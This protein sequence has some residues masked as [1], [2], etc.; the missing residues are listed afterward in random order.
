[1]PLFPKD[2]IE[3][4][5]KHLDFMTSTNF[6][7]QF[8]ERKEI[9]NNR[10]SFD[11][12]SKH[13]MRTAS[14][15]AN[16]N[17]EGGLIILGIDD[18]GNII[19]VKSI[20]E[21]GLNSI[22]Q[23]FRKLK[24][25]TFTN[26]NFNYTNIN[27]EEDFI[28]LVY[29]D[30]TTDAICETLEDFPR[31]WKRVGVQNM[32]L[33]FQELEALKRNKG[34][35]NFESQTCIEFQDND[36][37]SEIYKQFEK[38]FL[39]RRDS[40]FEYSKLE[41]LRNIG[42]ITSQNNIL[43]FTKSGYLY[44]SYNP[45]SIIAS[46]FVRLLKYDC[47][48]EDWR[49]NNNQPIFD[50]DFDGPIINIIRDV[51][52]FI[53][54]A[55]YFRTLYKR[56]ANGGFVNELEYPSVVVDEAI[57]NAIIHRDY[58]INVPIECIAFK[59]AFIVKS[60]GNIPQTAPKSFTL[61]E[62]SLESIPRNPKI[63]EWTRYMKDERGMT[64]IR[65][66]SEGTRT[67]R[68]KME[69]FDLPPPKYKNESFTKVILYNNFADREKRY[70]LKPE[71]EQNQ[72]ANL[73][74][75]SVPEDFKTD[76][77]HQTKRSLLL[78][79]RDV[80]EGNEWSIDGLYYSRLYAYRD[81]DNIGIESDFERVFKLY[82]IHEFQIKEYD[83]NY[84][85]S[86]DYRV[87]IKNQVDLQELIKYFEN[88]YFLGKNVKVRLGDS[89]EIAKLKTYN[90]GSSV[91]N[92][93]DV[94]D[95]DEISTTSIIPELNYRDINKVL[96]K[97]NI[98]VDLDKL[99]KSHSMLFHKNAA[100]IR[101]DKI[102]LTAKILQDRIFPIRIDKTEVRLNSNPKLF[103]KPS[104][105]SFSG[106]ITPLTVYHDLSE[107]YVVFHTGQIS[108]NILNGI[109]R[110]GS[111]E[112]DANDIEIIP[113]S[114][115]KYKLEMKELIVRL[116]VG[117]YKYRGSE[118]TF[119]TRFK[120]EKIFT[121]DD[122]KDMYNLVLDLIQKNPDWK[123]D[124]DISRIFL[125]YLPEEV[126]PKTDYQSP[127]YSIKKLLLGIGIPSQ[128][129]SRKTILS[130]DWK[131]LNLALNIVAKCKT[132]PWV[133]PDELPD[134]D[135]FIGL[136]YTSKKFETIKRYMGYANVFNQYGRWQLYQGN[137]ET[138]DYEDRHKFFGDLVRETLDKIQLSE[139]PSIVFHYSSKFSRKDIEIMWSAAKSIR[140][141]GKYTFI[142]INTTHNIRLFDTSAQTDGSLSRGSF[143]ITS[144]YQFYLSTTG[145]N[146][147]S[148]AMGTPLPLEV[149]VYSLT[150]DHPPNLK[151]I[152]KQI[153]YLT[154]LN[155]ASSKSLSRL[156][157]TIKY[158]KDIAKLSSIFIHKG[159]NL[160]IHKVL[161]E[162]PW[163]I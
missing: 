1:M 51:R 47:N 9:L 52:K 16:S 143:V 56:D 120:Y 30:H 36:L 161:Q 63:V 130:M 69:E 117:K 48:L 131:D 64:F 105:A 124:K 83:Q 140:P 78:A 147:Y 29:I 91:V 5:S 31:S 6:E 60:P 59:D 93:A 55:A 141:N 100:K 151:I 107:P 126:Y 150:L 87:R 138:F 25:L 119:G 49:A 4:P 34:I 71:L 26:Q 114:I 79:L 44:F 13:I 159:Q 115:T 7:G 113:L 28:I 17:R 84:Y 111:Y 77:R 61:D 152:A 2:L 82:N 73:F 54:D 106:K 102:L 97:K 53:L 92:F 110:F 62:I 19:G 90:Q 40:Q 163:F 157:V 14:G 112:K 67:M 23:I 12:V 33:S 101:A 137:P 15:F 57:V 94:N 144:P 27:E 109:T 86:F 116:I 66:L 118:R 38:D 135:F 153:L 85:L 24:N 43:Y 21:Q 42:A 76:D 8:F 18:E 46:S 132:I 41:I 10:N 58:A 95:V 125:V 88:N 81:D 45:R 68:M 32:A 11:R 123:G 99:L 98:R 122:I 136:S 72:F 162:T 158:A 70:S 89:L 75:L 148:K 74:Q 134:V 20:A 155:W 108:Q 103:L 3:D 146:I 22:F 50:R 145:Y 96:K 39:D 65:S 160:E 121:V 149:N 142:W 133:L 128:M 37:H 127:Y 129:V 139:T 35:I 154:K 80:L 156:P 104:S